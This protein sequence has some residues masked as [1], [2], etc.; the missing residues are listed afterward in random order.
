MNT[1]H[2][3]GRLCKHV[4]T[5]SHH[6][7]QQQH[8]NSSSSN[9]TP[10]TTASHHSNS[11]T[12][13]NELPT[14]FYILVSG[15]VDVFTYMNGTEQLLFTLEPGGV[16]GEIAVMFNIPQPFTMRSK[17]LSQVIQIS[18]NH[19][20]QMVQPFSDD[21]KAIISNFIQYMKDLKGKLPEE[22]PFVTEVLGELNLEKKGKSRSEGQQKESLVKNKSLSLQY[23]HFSPAPKQDLEVT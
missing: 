21:G 12:T 17:R 7:H 22:I 23:T 9:T 13:T 6:S 18:H 20:K 15:S 11:T 10:V 16:A 4:T 1:L 5:A 3:Q 8:S 2:L 14:D 19:F